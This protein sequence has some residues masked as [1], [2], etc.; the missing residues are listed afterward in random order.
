MTPD[1]LD[2]VASWVNTYAAVQPVQLVKD[3]KVKNT[4]TPCEPGAPGQRYRCGG[5]TDKAK[6]DADP[7]IGWHVL[8]CVGVLVRASALRHKTPAAMFVECDTLA[9]PLV[10][11]LV[12]RDKY[13]RVMR[14]L[15]FADYS[16]LDSTVGPDGKARLTKLAKI[17]PFLDR[18]RD[19]FEARWDVGQCVTVDKAC[20][21]SKSRYCPF[22][23]RNASKPIR[24]H[25]KIFCANCSETGYL[26]GFNVYQG[27]GSGSTAD[28]ICEL[29]HD[30][31][32]DT[33][34]V[35]VMDN[36]FAVDELTHRLFDDFGV[37]HITTSQLSSR[38]AKAQAGIS[39]SDFPARTQ[40]AY[41]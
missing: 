19:R 22:K 23:Q 25:I 35:F 7:V 17:K 34:K 10:K 6:W 14:F 9:D 26:F 3:S 31:W 15:V 13:D 16:D 11:A 1:L 27:A 37:Y 38:S 29:V 30:A 21:K 33:A 20:C 40:S 39:A 28:S 2:D 4:F 36:Y 5:E 32:I 24:I 41:T 12:C 18:L 8:L